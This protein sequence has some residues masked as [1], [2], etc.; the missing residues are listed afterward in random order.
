MIPPSKFQHNSREKQ[1]DMNPNSNKE[2]NLSEVLEMFPTLRPS[3][4]DYMVRERIVQGVRR[5]G[6]GAPRVYTEQGIE[7]IRSYLERRSDL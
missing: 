6:R 3:H 4:L 1:V 7:E 2:Y 5:Q